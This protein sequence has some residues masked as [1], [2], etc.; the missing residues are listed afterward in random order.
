MTIFLHKLPFRKNAIHFLAIAIFPY[1]NFPIHRRET[2]FANV[3][4]EISLK[5]PKIRHLWCKIFEYFDAFF[6]LCSSNQRNTDRVKSFLRITLT[7]LK[8]KSMKKYCAGKLNANR[9]VWCQGI[10]WREGQQFKVPTPYLQKQNMRQTII[11]EGSISDC[12]SCTNLNAEKLQISWRST[13][14]WYY[15][16]WL[17]AK[18]SKQL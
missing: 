15:I 5:Y 9:F 7:H 14:C 3:N 13:Y 1:G 18:R 12:S 2:G 6:S 4:C 17:I 8:W 16:L 10:T 11:K